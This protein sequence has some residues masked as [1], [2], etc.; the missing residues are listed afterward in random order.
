MSVWIAYIIGQL[1]HWYLKADATVKSASP[2]NTYREWVTRNRRA[3]VARLFIATLGFVAW[4]YYP[5]FVTHIGQILA[6]YLTPGA[7]RS[8]IEKLQFPLNIVTACAYGYLA[9]SLL[10]KLVNRFPMLAGEIPK[11]NGDSKPADEQ[12][13]PDPPNATGASAG[14]AAIPV[15]VCVWLVLT[16]LLLLAMFAPRAP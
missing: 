1:V 6:T 2:V 7:L 12:K 3:L 15:V 13:P 10:D 8:V 14:K 5:D 4:D 9:D 16:I 11:V